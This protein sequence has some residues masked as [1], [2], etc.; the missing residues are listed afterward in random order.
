M[1]FVGNDVRCLQQQQLPLSN[2]FGRGRRHSQAPEAAEYHRA[3]AHLRGVRK[4]DCDTIL[5]RWPTDEKQRTSQLAQRWTQEAAR[6]LDELALTDR[7]QR[8]A[9]VEKERYSK[10]LGRQT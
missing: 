3:V 6:R 4:R 1:A 7:T 2:D 8:L 10:K 9:E 5:Q